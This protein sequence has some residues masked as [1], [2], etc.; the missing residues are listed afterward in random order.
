MIGFSWKLQQHRERRLE[1]LLFSS[2]V[3]NENI[4]YR[5][6]LPLSRQSLLPFSMTGFSRKLQQH[7]LFFISIHLFT[8]ADDCLP[9][10]LAGPI[11]PATQMAQLTGGLGA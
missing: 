11:P 8:F 6:Q 5:F 10:G 7:R 1:F 4:G 9:T 3:G 2:P